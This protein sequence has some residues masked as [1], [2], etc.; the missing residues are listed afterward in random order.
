MISDPQ[1]VLQALALEEDDLMGPG[2][3]LLE[4]AKVRLCCHVLCEVMTYIDNTRFRDWICTPTRSSCMAFMH[5]ISRTSG[6][7]SSILV[8]TVAPEPAMSLRMAII[9]D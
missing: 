8:R 3:E 9:L 2:G 6:H 1:F 4:G 5:N 7:A